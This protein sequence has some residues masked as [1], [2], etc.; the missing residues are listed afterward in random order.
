MSRTY[1]KMRSHTYTGAYELCVRRHRPL[2]ELQ[3]RARLCFSDD[4]PPG[5]ERVSKLSRCLVWLAACVSKIK[6]ADFYRHPHILLMIERF[7]QWVNTH[8]QVRWVPMIEIARNFRAKNAAPTN[9]RMPKGFGE[10]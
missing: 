10:D 7:I 9:A 3:G 1:G 2:N 8:E 4:D 5:R 6:P